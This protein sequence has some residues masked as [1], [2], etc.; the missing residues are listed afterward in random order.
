MSDARRAANIIIKAFKRGNKLLICGNGGSAAE[1]QHFAGELVGKFMYTR[2]GLPAIALTTDT[3]ILTSIGN[4]L[5]FDVV[6]SRQVEALG[7][8][9]DVLLTLSTSGRSM[10]ILLAQKQAEN[11]G[12]IVIDLSRKGNNTPEIQENQLK[13]IHKICGIV[14]KAFI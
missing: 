3:S 14:E 4:D 5:G 2:Q 11:M 13:L 12:M 8:R 7:K 9:G 6:F 10:N 1:S